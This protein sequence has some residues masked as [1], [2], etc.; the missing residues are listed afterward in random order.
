MFVYDGVVVIAN[1]EEKNKEEGVS[2]LE[3]SS[4]FFAHSSFYVNVLNQRASFAY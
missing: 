1:N 4:H 2:V 3:V